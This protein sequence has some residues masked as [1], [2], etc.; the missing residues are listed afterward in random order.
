M[1]TRVAVNAPFE[2]TVPTAWTRVPTLRSAAV[3][4]PPKLF[5]PPGPKPPGPNPRALPGPRH[6]PPPRPSLGTAD[7]P[8]LALG[9]AAWSGAIRL[10]WFGSPPAPTVAL[11]AGRLPNARL[12]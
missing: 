7:A 5:G 6:P 4:I 9:D 12:I 1:S 11:A 10:A 8:A 3:V 2:S